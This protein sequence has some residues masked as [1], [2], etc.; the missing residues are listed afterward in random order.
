MSKTSISFSVPERLWSSFKEQTDALF[1]TRSPFL[2]HVLSCEIPYLVQDLQGL[3]LSMKAKQFV[4]SNLKEL[5]APSPNVNIE[6]EQETADAL[7]TAVKDHNLVRDAFF[8]RLLVLLRSTDS[9]LNHL[10]VPLAATDKGLRTMLQ[11]MPS[12]PLKAMEA[13]RDDPL[14]YIRHHVEHIHGCGLYRV[15]LGQ[16]WLS[17]YIEDEFVEGTRKHARWAKALSLL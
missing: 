8:C 14:F 1:L 4:N 12:S 7:R 10:E 2:D 11:E 9:L 16:P 5:V 17:C 15:S 13:V 6:V 3:K